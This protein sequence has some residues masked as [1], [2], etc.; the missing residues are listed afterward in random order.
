M[1]PMCLCVKNCPNGNG[2][3]SYL[4]LRWRPSTPD[5]YLLKKKTLN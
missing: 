5:Y 1:C 4:F 3:F 2:G